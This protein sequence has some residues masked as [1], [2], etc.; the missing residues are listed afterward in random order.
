[1]PQDSAPPNEPI[2]TPEQEE[3]KARAQP[4]LHGDIHQ[5]HETGA[6]VIRPNGQ[7]ILMR[8]I[9]REDAYGLGQGVSYDSRRAVAHEVLAVGS[10]VDRWLDLHGVPDDARDTRTLLRR[11][12]AWLFGRGAKMGA[13]PRPG[14]HVFV[15]SAAC[16]RAS[17]TDRTCRLWFA[18]IE[19]VSGAWNV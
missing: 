2:L 11:F 19:D 8:A 17:K 12:R 15:L 5:L 3:S 1:M 9:L 10:S 18:H 4:Y 14:D 6:I 7:R 13:R 16:D